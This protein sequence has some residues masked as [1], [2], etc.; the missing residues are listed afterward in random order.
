MKVVLETAQRRVVLDK[1]MFGGMELKNEK[2]LQIKE[3]KKI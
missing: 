2:I 1:N 3:L